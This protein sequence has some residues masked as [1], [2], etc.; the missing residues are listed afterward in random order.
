MAARI[1]V[2]TVVAEIATDARGLAHVIFCGFS[3]DSAAH[4]RDAFEA[5]GLV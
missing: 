3:A 2:G 4:H 5:L 1:A